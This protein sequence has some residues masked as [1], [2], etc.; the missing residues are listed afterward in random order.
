M[1]TLS[2]PSLLTS[3]G[4]AGAHTDVQAIE[5]LLWLVRSHLGVEVA[6]VSAFTDGQQIIHAASGETAAM[7]VPV[8]AGTD[9]QGSF[10][11]RVMAG[12]L[13]PVVTDARRHPI[14]RDLPVTRDL[15][16]GS[17]VG[18]PWRGPGGGVAGMLCCVSRHPDPSLDTDAVRFMTF[19]ADL[20]S[21]HM[22]GPLAELRQ[23]EHQA[24]HS[25][26]SILEQQAIRM[27]FQP[28]VELTGGATVAYEALARFDAAVFSSPDKAFAAATQSGLGVGLELLAVRRALER[29]PDLPDGFW[30]GVN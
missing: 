3:P 10:C 1:P 14:T 26:R 21:D 17:Y 8:G 29:L 2:A 4:H 25:V 11:L 20:I 16:I 22:G 27:V 30:L 5:R 9:L 18:V 19:V 15:N 6:W 23:A 7:N 28:V 13:P 24:T 12:T